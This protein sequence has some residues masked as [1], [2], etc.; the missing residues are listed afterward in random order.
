MKGTYLPGLYGIGNYQV[1]GSCGAFS[2]TDTSWTQITNLSRQITTH[3]RPVL[4][5]LIPDGT[6]NITDWSP[7]ASGVAFRIYR[8]AT[9]IWESLNFA[10]VTSIRGYYPRIWCFD[11]YVNT[12]APAQYTY[13]MKYQN[14][15]G[16]TT[17]SYW[18]LFAWEMGT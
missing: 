3:G 8:D 5:G 12:V 18:R 2:G 17:L 1:S 9:V 13:S 15:A 11:D 14:V 16:T 4:I 6:T 10:M 7:S